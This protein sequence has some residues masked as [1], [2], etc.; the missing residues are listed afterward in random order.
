MKTSDRRW[1]KKVSGR[2]QGRLEKL[3]L[4]DAPIPLNEGLADTKAKKYQFLE[5]YP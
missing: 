4:D 5:V 1:V 2:N 3:N